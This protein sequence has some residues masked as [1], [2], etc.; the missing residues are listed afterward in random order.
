M[1]SKVCILTNYPYTQYKLK[2]IEA[3]ADYFYDKSQDFNLLKSLIKEIAEQLK[4][5]ISETI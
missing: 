2:S 3:G 4:D 1:K 5:N